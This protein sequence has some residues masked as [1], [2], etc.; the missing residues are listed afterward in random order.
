MP[1]GREAD[2]RTFYEGLPG[3]PEVPKPA[4]LMKRGGCWFERGPLKAHP[5]FLTGDLSGLRERLRA[6]GCPVRTDEPL[7]GYDHAGDP[8]GNRIELMEPK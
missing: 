1:V 6:A 2:A 5:A 3:I 4:N 7:E 8:F